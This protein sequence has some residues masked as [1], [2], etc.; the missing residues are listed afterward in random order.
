MKRKTKRWRWGIYRVLSLGVAI[1]LAG[2]SSEANSTPCPQTDCPKCPQV[3]TTECPEAYCPECPPV[4]AQESTSLPIPEAL[5]AKYRELW[6]ISVHGKSNTATCET[7]HTETEN[8]SNNMFLITGVQISG[9]GSET[10]CLVCHQGQNASTAINEAIEAAGVAGEDTVD[11]NL[12]FVEIPHPAPVGAQLGAWGGGAATDMQTNL[13]MP[14][15][16]MLKAMIPVVI[17]MIHIACC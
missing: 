2:C 16:P 5:L 9:T 10:K 15:L 13:M 17:V 14:A 7:C 6:E 12:A 4:E 11:E 1:F 8:S 3:V